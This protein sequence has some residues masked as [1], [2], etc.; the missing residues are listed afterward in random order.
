MSKNDEGRS[1]LPWL[2]LDA[3]AD[4]PQRFADEAWEFTDDLAGGHLNWTAAREGGLS[5]EFFAIWAEPKR[6]V[7]QYANR[8]LKLIDAVRQQVRRHPQQ[9]RLCVSAAEI[10]QAH[11]DGRFAVMMGLEGGHSIEGSLALLRMYFELGVRYMTL[12]WANSNEWADSSG[13]LADETVRHHGGLTEFGRGVVS[14]MNRLGMIVDV[15]HVSDATFTDAL[16]TSRAP[17]LATHSG[18]RALAGSARNLTDEMLRRIADG[19]GAA[20]V[21]F[22]PAFLDDSWRLAWEQL[23]PQRLAA[24]QAEEAMYQARGTVRPPRAGH[25][26]DLEFATQLQRP[27]VEAIARHLDHMIK[28]AGIEHVGLGSDFDGVPDLPEGMRSAAD[29][30]ALFEELRQRGYADAEL[31]KIAGG[32][33]LRVMTTVASCADQPSPP[34]ANFERL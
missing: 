3:H 12:T 20:M 7:G 21:N 23:A 18:V 32:N 31:E 25:A 26:I 24:H 34:E 19:G 30:P 15:S 27:P 4:T 22:Y 16:D 9:L 11:R 8:T 17:V 6:W 28:I 5:G 1:G 13:D 33:L 14:E 29:L 10:V 2:V